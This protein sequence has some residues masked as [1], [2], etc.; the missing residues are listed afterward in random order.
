MDPRPTLLGAGVAVSLAVGVIVGL[1]S[2]SAVLTALAVQGGGLLIVGVGTAI[3]R[4]GYRIA[5]I[6]LTIAG[7]C[8]VA[9]AV[10]LFV[11][12]SEALG[13]TL[14]FLPGLLGLPLLVA[15]LI[16]IRGEGS[17]SLVKLGTGG[18]FLS[19]VLSGLFLAVGDT[20]M[21]L[22]AVATIVAWSAAENAIGV[23]KQLGRDA[24]VRRL[25][26]V[27]VAGTAVVGLAGVA[28]IS[29]LRGAARTGL[30]LASFTL[31]AFALLLL[32]AAMHR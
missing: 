32:V 17:R 1:D 29:L 13:H 30:S 2:G 25:E 5:G 8:V 7:G 20:R 12:E 24:T 10:A 3:R 27:H 31:L 9:A 18:L 21:L 22:V 28:T 11:T 23:G 16:P 4:R 15:A 6:S 26:A 14:R 19:V